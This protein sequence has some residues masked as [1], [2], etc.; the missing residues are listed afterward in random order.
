V[1]HYLSARAEW[2]SPEKAGKGQPVVW[3]RGETFPG[4]VTEVTRDVLPVDLVSG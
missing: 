2:S 3:I 4:K 1:S